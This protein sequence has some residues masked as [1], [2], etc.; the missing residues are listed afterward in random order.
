[1]LLYALPASVLRPGCTCRWGLLPMQVRLGDC[2]VHDSWPVLSMAEV[3]EHCMM[4]SSWNSQGSGPEGELT[5]AWVLMAQC[6]AQMVMSILVWEQ[7]WLF[8]PA[9]AGG[10]LPLQASH[11]CHLPLQPG[12]A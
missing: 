3:H 8:S 9:K 10:S 7:L 2:A 5:L 12:C 4:R 11:A 1:M 6:C